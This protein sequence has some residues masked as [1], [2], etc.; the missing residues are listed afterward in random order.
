MLI[1]STIFNMNDMTY[2]KLYNR[3]YPT[4]FWYV[5]PT[6]SQ[7]DFVAEFLYTLPRQLHC[8]S[9]EKWRHLGAGCT[10]S[11]FQIGPNRALKVFYKSFT[12]TKKTV[13]KLLAIRSPHVYRLIDYWKIGD[14]HFVI[15]PV[16]RK[17]KGNEGDLRWAF[18][19][20]C[21][22]H[23]Q[24]SNDKITKRARRIY[25]EVKKYRLELDDAVG[26]NLMFDKKGRM[27][28]IDLV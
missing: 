18:E 10:G 9:I 26:N 24:N 27:V 7:L 22:G 21:S 20:C 11:V 13:E 25:N 23:L 16:Y 28:L 1:A 3:L 14:I 4:S 5:Q 19:Y 8:W 2:R 12:N 15:T 17:A 6:E